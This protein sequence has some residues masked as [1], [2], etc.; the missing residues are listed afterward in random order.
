MKKRHYKMTDGQGTYIYFDDGS[1]RAETNLDRII[2]NVSAWFRTRH[3]RR[4]QKEFRRTGTRYYGNGGTIHS[5]GHL[6]V[7]VYDGKVVAVWFRCQPLAFEHHDVRV[8]RAMSMQA[9]Y[10]QS[11]HPMPTLCGVEVRDVNAAP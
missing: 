5:S 1:R 9:M 2:E 11:A 3:W 7:E 10:T 6:D 8:E 4:R